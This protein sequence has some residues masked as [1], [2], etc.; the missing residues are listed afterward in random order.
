MLEIKRS[1]GG[2]CH[3]PVQDWRVSQ[4]RNQ[5]KTEIYFVPELCSS[6][7]WLYL[8]PC[9]WRRHFPPKRLSTSTGLRGAA[10]QKIKLFTLRFNTKVAQRTSQFDWVSILFAQH[11]IQCKVTKIISTSSNNC[12]NVCGVASMGNYSKDRSV[13]CI[14]AN[15]E[16]LSFYLLWSSRWQ[17]YWNL[18]LGCK[19]MYCIRR[20]WCLKHRI[21]NL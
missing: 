3:F 13:Y 7:A 18:R 10:P 9:I 21:Q 20:C 4:L 8:R 17:L 16:P 19:A 1:F 6:L 12:A 14:Q 11:R 15:A 5:Q 2:I